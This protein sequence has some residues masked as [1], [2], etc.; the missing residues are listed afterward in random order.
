MRKRSIEIVAV[1]GG[2][3]TI[4]LGLWVRLATRSSSFSWAASVG[5]LVAAVFAFVVALWA[6]RPLRSRSTSY[7]R[8]VEVLVEVLLEGRNLKLTTM[9]MKRLEELGQ[10]RPELRQDVIDQL[11]NYLRSAARWVQDPGGDAGDFLVEP[12]LQAS[13]T[14]A[15][16]IICR[17][18]RAIDDPPDRHEFWPDLSVDLRDTLLLD[19]DFGYCKVQ[20]ASFERAQFAGGASFKSAS[21]ASYALFS[22]ARF[23]DFVVFD[24][25]LCESDAAF[26][27]T[28]FRGGSSFVRARFMGDAVFTRSR[29]RGI[30]NFTWASVDGRAWF[31]QVAVDRL[32]IFERTSFQHGAVFS[33]ASFNEDCSFAFCHFTER[34]SFD[35]ATFRGNVSFDGSTITGSI[36]FKNTRFLGS[37]SFTDVASSE[38]LELNPSQYG[39]L[40]ASLE[41]QVARGDRLAIGDLAR[42]LAA[43]GR[44]KEAE[45]WFR[46]AIEAGDTA[47]MVDLARSLA[48]SGRTEEALSWF[49]RAI[50]AGDTAAMVD[51][52][53][54][55]PRAAVLKK[56][57]PGSAAPSRRVIRRRWSV[58]REPCRERPY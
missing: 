29:F 56:P 5:S 55:L 46:R 38:G 41:A 27:I 8:D 3:A 1:A 51:L 26:D 7:A 28:S 48:A 14:L 10:A 18:L 13:I 24:D 30:L 54:A 2:I 11:C 4:V 21:F 15:Q 17:H 50:E 12:G 42:S 40:A 47:A 45:S 34:T 53:R 52:A 32:A 43:S 16:S 44:K 22:T 19:F 31:D 23:N 20:R 37:V 39:N 25:F 49:R 33:G 57:S 36:S 6:L 35:D 9:A 58:W